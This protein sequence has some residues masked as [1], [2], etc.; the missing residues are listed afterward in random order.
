MSEIERPRLPELGAR[1]KAARIKAGWPTAR[2]AAERCGIREDA[3]GRIERGLRDPFFSTVVAMVEDLGLDPL[4]V[5]PP[6]PGPDGEDPP[7]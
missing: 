4:L 7:C 3:Y 1:L 5:F 6:A 2:A